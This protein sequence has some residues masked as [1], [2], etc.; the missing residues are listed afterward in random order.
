MIV[1]TRVRHR[2]VHIKEVV[3]RSLSMLVGRDEF[4]GSEPDNAQS[5]PLIFPIPQPA[6]N[7]TSQ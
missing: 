1:C 2:C 4:Y 5:L 6:T 7:K 3:G